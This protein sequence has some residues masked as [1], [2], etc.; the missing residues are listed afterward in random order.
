MTETTPWPETGRPRRA[1]VSSF[2]ISGTNAHVILE[3]APQAL[4]PAVD[5]RVGGEP[6]ALVQ[7]PVVPWVISGRSES[8]LR[9]QAERLAAAVGGLSPVDVGFSLVASRSVFEHRAVVLAGERAGFAAGLSALVVGEP[10]AG[11]VRGQVAPGKL[12][13]LFSGQGSQR[14]GMGRELY[15]AFP[16]FAEAFDEVCARFDGLL[17]RPLREVVFEDGEALDA[18]GF[19]QCGLFALEVALFRLVSS[20]GVTPDVVGGHSVG[21]IVAA[22]VAGVFSLE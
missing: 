12:A 1:G 6:V 7:P 20:W 15:E 18:T 21:E 22:F 14:A 11:V 16:V 8:A 9:G 19:T 3:Q 10:A 17:D 13:V 5:D 4:V 2:G